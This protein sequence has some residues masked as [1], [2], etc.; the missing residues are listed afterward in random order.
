MS[1]DR[2]LTERIVLP[3][4][5][6]S[7]VQ[8]VRDDMGEDGVCLAPVVEQLST[9][10]REPLADIAVGRHGKLTNRAVRAA[11]AA[12]TALGNNTYG[13]QWLAIARFIVTLTEEDIITVTEGSAFSKAWDIMVELRLGSVSDEESVARAEE[14]AVALRKTLASQGLFT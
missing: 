1:T 4:L 13:V 5:M 3:A 11:T 2:R 12:M 10:L 6:Q 14:L 7:L 8:S 9:S